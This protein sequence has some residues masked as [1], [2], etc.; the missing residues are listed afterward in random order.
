VMPGGVRSFLRCPA[1]LWLLPGGTSKRSH[2]DEVNRCKPSSETRDPCSD[3]ASSRAFADRITDRPA[4][5][6]SAA[7]DTELQAVIT[8]L[9]VYGA[10]GGA[11][12]KSL[13]AAYGGRMAAAWVRLNARRE[14]GAFNL[15][16]GARRTLQLGP[17]RRSGDQ[18]CTMRR[19]GPS[20]TNA[21]SS[22]EVTMASRLALTRA[23]RSLLVMC[24][25]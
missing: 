8:F 4:E 6:S 12:S 14:R 3:R 17:A 24:Q 11:S 5:T 13:R 15:S 16:R 21:A 2:G 9:A 7:V 25:S 20:S 10:P 22:N 23:S 18:R 1:E 19:S